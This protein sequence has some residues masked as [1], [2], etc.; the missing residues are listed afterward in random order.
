MT[1]DE[2][3]AVTFVVGWAQGNGLPSDEQA[4]LAARALTTADVRLSTTAALHERLIQLRAGA[5]QLAGPL[6]NAEFTAIGT[7]LNVLDRIERRT[8]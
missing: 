1:S 5:Y 2:A 6:T 4:T 7:V 8:L 3:L